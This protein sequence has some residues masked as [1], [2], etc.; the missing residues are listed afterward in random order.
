MLIP[1]NESRDTLEKYKELRN[2]IADLIRSVTNN[3][4]DYDEKNMKRKFASDDDL[5]LKKTLELHSLVIVVRPDF[6]EDNKYCPQVFLD[7]CLCKI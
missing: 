3:S 6:H 5:P 2:K 1:T 4:D 7:G